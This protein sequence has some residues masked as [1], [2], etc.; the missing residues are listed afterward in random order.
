MTK[1]L[2][3]D[4]GPLTP[5]MPGGTSDYDAIYVGL[6]A[7][8][9]IRVGE[10][11]WYREE[12]W[13][14]VECAVALANWLDAPVGTFLYES[15]D[16]DQPWLLR[17]SPRGGEWL[18][19]A[20]WSKRDPIE[21]TREELLEAAAAFVVAVDSQLLDRFGADLSRYRT[22][23]RNSNLDVPQRSAPRIVRHTLRE[24]CAN[25]KPGSS[26]TRPDAPGSRQASVVR[27]SRGIT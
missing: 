23:I 9:E 3:F 12:A 7:T 10:T 4:I 20:A 15:M 14:A 26:E 16:A 2:R 19:E 27:R 24:Q 25:R 17:F 21:V 18:I 1:R 13:N 8:F 6:E 5:T 11:V 22:G